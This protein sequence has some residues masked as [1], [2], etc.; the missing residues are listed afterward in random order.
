M[1][2][3]FLE[4]SVP[5]TKAFT[6]TTKSSYPSAFEFTSHTHTLD[7]LQGFEAALQHHGAAGH[8]LLKGE[9]QRTLNSQSRAGSTDSTTLTSWICFDFDGAK[10]MSVVTGFLESVGLPDHILQYSAS[11]GVQGQSSAVKLHVFA[12]LDK[13]T[14]PVILKQWLQWQNLTDPLLRAHT[15]LTKTSVALSYVLDPTVA[16]NDKLIY[17]SPPVCTPP[18]LDTLKASGEPRIR[19]VPG[20]AKHLDTERLFSGMPSKDQLRNLVEVRINELRTAAN[21]GPRPSFNFKIDKA[22]GTEYLDKPGATSITGS[23]TDRGFVY[24]NLNGGDSWGY[25][26]PETDNTFVYNFKDEPV[27]K[28]QQLDPEFYKASLP[29]CRAAAKAAQLATY[30]ETSPEIEIANP[31]A[32]KLY[33]VFCD[34][35]TAAYYKAVYNKTSG[36]WERIDRASNEKQLSDFLLQHG[37]SDVEVIPLWDLVFDPSAPALDIAKRKVNMYDPPDLIH[38]A[39][40]RVRDNPETVPADMP[41]TV[42]KIIWSVVG[43]DEATFNH[44]VNWIRFVVQER[45]RSQTAWLF[46]GVQGTGKGLLAH[47]IL[48]PLIGLTNS[49]FFDASVLEDKFTDSLESSILTFIDELTISDLEDSSK[50]MSSLKSRITE[51]TVVI[52]KMRTSPYEAP[53]YNNY[54]CFSNSTEQIA[55]EASDRRYNVGVYQKTKLNITDTEVNELLPVELPDF[56]AW[57]LATPADEV[58]AR[59]VIHNQARADM[60]AVSMNSIDTVAK[61]LLEGNL[62]ELYNMRVNQAQVSGD[63]L[64]TAFRYSELLDDIIYHDITKLQREQVMLFFQHCAGATATSPI[65]VTKFLAHHGIHIKPLN[66]HGQIVRGFS[67]DWTCDAAWYQ[68]RK[69][70]LIAKRG[71][72]K[73]QP[74]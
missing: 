41:P 16:Q 24:L 12:L 64:N 52:R 39:A 35:K 25:Y 5:L 59:S 4:A 23:K 47:K 63:L 34:N 50:I 67:V 17:I 22:T 10:D 58:K 14:S 43:G 69:D 51:P 37:Q 28:L 42:H 40:A 33:M 36:R 55:I 48:R 54:I 31:D 72:K 46:N 19:F 29:A 44:F 20:L 3:T 60:Q 56:A 73:P 38:T 1:K 68:D 27:Y 26:Y 45:R 66:I 71:I 13:P 49:S 2:V 57:L 11:H 74:V 70:E 8:C 53:N 7:T 30:S 62:E 32:T 65:K 21:L 18:T 6:E 61:Y 15:A 9:I